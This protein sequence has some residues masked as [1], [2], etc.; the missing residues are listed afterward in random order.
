MKLKNFIKNQKKENTRETKT[1]HTTLKPNKKQTRASEKA[2]EKSQKR[3][4]LLIFVGFVILGFTIIL[5]LLAFIYNNYILN[6]INSGEIISPGN[7]NVIE[8]DKARQ[9][10][11]DKD[12]KIE[13]FGYASGS[14]TL[15]LSI[16]DGPTV[17][18]SDIVEFENQAEIL[19]KILYSLK[20][21]GKTAKIVDLRYNRPIVKF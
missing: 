7:L 5:F 2:S 8:I 6:R 14:S 20:S 19:D 17:Y 13:N 9:I 16:E 11:L 1:F 4:K 3:T 18:F 21:E 15:L 12:I 10:L